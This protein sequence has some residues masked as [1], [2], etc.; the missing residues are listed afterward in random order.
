MF[1]CCYIVSTGCWR[2]Y[3]N[4]T[5]V[6]TLSKTLKGVSVNVLASLW[7]GLMW[8][9][10][11]GSCFTC[12]WLLLYA[13]AVECFL[14]IYTGRGFSWHVKPQWCNTCQQSFTD[15]QCVCGGI[16]CSFYPCTCTWTSSIWPI[17]FL[18][19][20]LHQ[21]WFAILNYNNNNYF[22]LTSDLR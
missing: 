20:E 21:L 4:W 16:L 1:T 8:D 7:E 9:A 2:G 10:V 6:K 14:C 11:F 15:L 22:Q 18:V 3:Y 12:L 5:V 13:V 17:C 19:A